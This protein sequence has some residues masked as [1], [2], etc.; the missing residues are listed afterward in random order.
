ML[1]V[2]WWFSIHVNALVWSVEVLGGLGQRGYVAMAVVDWRTDG[3]LTGGSL[4]DPL[5]DVIT[6]LSGWGGRQCPWRCFCGQREGV[7]WQGC[8]SAS[9]RAAT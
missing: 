4:H 1:F 5:P 2:D 7:L 8:G 3:A 6:T 9:G